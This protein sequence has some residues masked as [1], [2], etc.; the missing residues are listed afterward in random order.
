MLVYADNRL[1][2]S[3]STSGILKLRSDIYFKWQVVDWSKR[4]GRERCKWLPHRPSQS[5]AWH[6]RC[7]LWYP[8]SVRITTGDDRASCHCFYFF[9]G[10]QMRRYL[11][12]VFISFFGIDTFMI[13]KYDISFVILKPSEKYTRHSSLE[14][15][16]PGTRSPMKRTACARGLSPASLNVKA[17]SSSSSFVASR[18]SIHTVCK[19]CPD[20]QAS[21][22]SSNLK[23]IKPLFTPRRHSTTQIFF[24]AGT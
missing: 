12:G 18:V 17:L 15:T 4:F 3:H 22:C 21:S 16:A 10:V 7:H 8:Q 23:K 11:H 19:I 13:W 14:S 9:Y 2:E 1:A 20:I 24:D 6:N 5:R